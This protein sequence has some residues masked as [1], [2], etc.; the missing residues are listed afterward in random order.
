MI[1]VLPL[2]DFNE[3]YKDV[4]QPKYQGGPIPPVQLEFT[5]RPKQEGLVP[6]YYPRVLNDMLPDVDETL[7]EV[8]EEDFF[9]SDMV[10]DETDA[11]DGNTGEP[12]QYDEDTASTPAVT[13]TTST[14]STPK[15]LLP[16]RGRFTT[17]APATRG[18]SIKKDAP[19]VNDEEFA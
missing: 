6:L 17:P 2:D 10:S 8:H 13:T 14:P 7:T 1:C 12:D 4:I 18:R 9:E 16:Q 5:P 19:S 3:L 15:S 11:H